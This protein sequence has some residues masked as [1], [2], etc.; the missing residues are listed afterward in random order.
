MVKTLMHYLTGPNVDPMD[1][2]YPD[3]DHQRGPE[4]MQNNRKVWHDSMRLTHFWKCG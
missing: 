3:P 4:I 1:G 2:M